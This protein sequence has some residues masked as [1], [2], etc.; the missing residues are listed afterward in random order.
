MVKLS[1]FDIIIKNGK[2]I[3][4]N[5]LFDGDLA[6]D[7]GVIACLGKSIE[8]RADKIIDVK[9]KL[10]LPGLVDPHVHMDF[11]ISGMANRDDFKSGSIAAAFSGITTIIDFAIQEKDRSA[12]EAIK[13]RRKTADKKVVIDYSL[14]S[15]LTDGSER[16][17]DEIKTI[18]NYGVPSFKLFMVY[19]KEGVMIDDGVL[20]TI[21]EKVKSC[22]GLVGVHA[23]NV[24]IIDYLTEKYVKEG[25]TNAEYHAKSRPNISEEEAIRR[26]VLLAKSLG[27]SLYIFHMSTK[28]G[29]MAVK[30]ARDNGADIL[31]ETCPHYLTLSDEMYLRPDGN[32]WIMSPPLR[33]KED[34]EALWN[35]IIQRYVKVIG[36]D[37]SAWDSIQK[38]EDSF[39][40]V[41]N[42]VGSIETSLP[43]M[44][45]EGVSNGRISINTLIKVMS[46]NAAKIF[47]LYP[48]KGTL[49]VGSDADIVI[50]DP[51]QERTL[52]CDDL[53]MNLDYSIYEGIKVKGFPVMTISRGNIIVENGHFQGK[54]GEGRFIPRKIM[55]KEIST[56]GS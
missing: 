9:G 47:G 49:M 11:E 7:S 38:S 36:S 26:A 56:N 16:T 8:N 55:R 14:H 6:I 22:G 46:E 32:N 24:A 29:L 33:K 23:E 41:M 52:S 35:G 28:E 1:V 50:V 27:A 15:C 31:A 51:T 21:L 25:K 42:G 10:V 44:F 43:L 30:E 39:H 54:P 13:K 20:Y 2:I 45:S 12:L 17:L 19:K 48:Q 18:V 40:K 53:H 37:H 3:T 34:I 5:G 4:A